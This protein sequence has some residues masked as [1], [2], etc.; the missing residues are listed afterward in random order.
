MSLALLV[1]PVRLHAQP[2]RLMDAET[3]DRGAKEIRAAAARNT[4]AVRTTTP[5]ELDG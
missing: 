2:P 1:A 5:M 4:T 3:I